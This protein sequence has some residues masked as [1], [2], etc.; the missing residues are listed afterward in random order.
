MGVCIKELGWGETSLFDMSDKYVNGVGHYVIPEL[1]PPP[2]FNET[3]PELFRYAQTAYQICQT[4]KELLGKLQAAY[5]DQQRTIGH[6]HA[7][8][9]DQAK[10]FESQLKLVNDVMA[11]NT[12]WRNLVSPDGADEAADGA[13]APLAP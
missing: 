6:Q 3:K 13:A 2:S 9:E 4:Q 7:I 5:T 8:I 10:L 1:P 11:E 12:M